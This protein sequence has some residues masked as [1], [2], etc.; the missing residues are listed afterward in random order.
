MQP[1]ILISRQVVFLEAGACTSDMIKLQNLLHE[2]RKCNHMVMSTNVDLDKLQSDLE[3]R[4]TDLEMAADALESLEKELLACKAARDETEMRLL[5]LKKSHDQKTQRLRAESAALKEELAMALAGSSHALGGTPPANPLD[6]LTASGNDPN[7]CLSSSRSL[8]EAGELAGARGRHYE[9]D[10]TTGGDVMA[11]FHSI[12]EGSMHD[13]MPPVGNARSFK[14][15][16]HDYSG[17]ADMSA[18]APEAPAKPHADEAILHQAVVL[19]VPADNVCAPKFHWYEHSREGHVSAGTPEATAKPHTDDEILH[20]AVVPD[21]PG[22]NACSPE[23]HWHVHSREGHVSVGA[24]EAPSKQHTDEEILSRAV[25]L[26][27]PADYACSSQVP[28]CD[29]VGKSSEMASFRVE[30]GKS[31]AVQAQEKVLSPEGDGNDASAQ[32]PM[33]ACEGCSQMLFMWET[34][35]DVCIGKGKGTGKSKRKHT[36]KH[37]R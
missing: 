30:D 18:V 36:G 37:K 1:K 15:H 23:F 25:G 16:M 13:L 24:P 12:V 35:C 11:K 14:S 27:A 26:D 28:S 6:P 4:D 9:E 2:D 7:L 17:G 10:G 20:Q 3:Q 31:S 32:E 21:V 8:G 33:W 5:A 22:G 29:T 34:S 19:D